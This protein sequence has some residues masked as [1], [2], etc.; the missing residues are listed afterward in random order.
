MRNLSEYDKH[1]TFANIKYVSE[2][3]IKRLYSSFDSIDDE[4]KS[5]EEE[6]YR[7]SSL[8]FDPDTMDETHGMDEAYHEGVNHYLVHTHMKQ[9]FLNSSITWV[10]HHFE[11]DCSRLF[12]TNDGNKKKNILLN[13]GIDTSEASPWSKCNNELRLLANAIKHGEGESS[14]KLETLR[15][16]L[17]KRSF[18]LQSNFEIETSIY[19]V[20]HY[21]S[22]LIEFWEAFFNAALPKLE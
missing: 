14:V 6:A 10:F 13:L 11:K 7:I 4:S 19:D 9:E 20:E 18:F 21:I 22:A 16:D 8:Y 2:T 15:P 12:E 1:E 17:F 5:V 3:I